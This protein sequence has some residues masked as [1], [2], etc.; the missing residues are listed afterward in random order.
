MV[1]HLLS[2]QVRAQ[3]DKHAAG[4]YYTQ[5]LMPICRILYLALSYFITGGMK[6]TLHSQQHMQI[7]RPVTLCQQM[8]IILLDDMQARQQITS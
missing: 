6:R 2:G 8:H 7:G 1:P 4:N 5:G 3:F